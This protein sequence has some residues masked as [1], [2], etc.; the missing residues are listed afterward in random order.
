ME[1]MSLPIPETH[2]FGVYDGK[3]LVFERKASGFLMKAFEA[4]E[5]EALY[6]DRVVGVEHMNGGRRFGAIV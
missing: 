2:G 3:V 1:K 4:I 6:G 5:F